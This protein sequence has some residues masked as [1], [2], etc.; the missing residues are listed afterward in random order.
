MLVIG[1]VSRV[2]WVL[3]VGRGVFG[4]LEVEPWHAHSATC[5]GISKPRVSWEVFA[6]HHH[7]LGLEISLP[8]VRIHRHR[9]CVVRLCVGQANEEGPHTPQER[10]SV[11]WGVYQSVACFRLRVH[12]TSHATW[13]A[14]IAAEVLGE[15]CTMMCACTV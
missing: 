11:W 13:S 1:D 7:P 9:V 5:F 15:V 8:R 6:L 3:V 4:S 14:N 12:P 2:L 10:I